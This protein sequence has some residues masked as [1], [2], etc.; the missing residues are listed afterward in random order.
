M[1]GMISCVTVV[2]YQWRTWEEK[3]LFNVITG[4]RN[5]PV[6]SGRTGQLKSLISSASKRGT[7]ALGTHHGGL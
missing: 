4:V 5:L 1:L 3:Y 2:E 6:V 7:A